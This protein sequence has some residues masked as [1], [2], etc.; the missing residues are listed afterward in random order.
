MVTGFTHLVG[1][2][3]W[4]IL[5]GF[6]FASLVFVTY[7]A[8]QPMTVTEAPKGMSYVEFMKD[9]LDAAKIVK[10]SQCGWGMML[11]LAAIG[12]IYS[13]VYTAVG[14]N[15]HGFLA[16]VTA[17]DRDIPKGVAGAQWYEVPGI[18]WGVVE[19]LSWTMLGKQRTPGCQFRSVK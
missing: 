1:K 3:I 2:L 10:P 19:H 6:V 5:V 14:V 15:P 4:N 7:K 9:R 16:K 17:P 11:S 18:W 12:P 13:I 8:N